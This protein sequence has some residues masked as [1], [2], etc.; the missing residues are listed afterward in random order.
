MIELKTIQ[1]NSNKGG[2]VMMR[3]RKENINSKS[4]YQF[5]GFILIL[6]IAIGGICFSNSQAIFYNAIIMPCIGVLSVILLGKKYYWVPISI[7][8]LSCTVLVIQN[9]I[10]SMEWE[11]SLSGI[12]IMPLILTMIY[13]I[14]VSMGVGIGLLFKYTFSKK[15]G[16]TKSKIGRIMAGILGILLS[17]IIL[18]FTDSLLG[19]PIAAIQ[20]TKGAKV[21]AKEHY[22]HLELEASKATYTFKFHT[23]MVNLSS[24]SSVDTHFYIEYKDGKVIY[25][26]YQSSLEEK[27][28][29][30]QRLEERCTSDVLKLLEQVPGIKNNTTFVTF[31]KE[32]MKDIDAEE[33]DS[34]W[35]D[36]PYDQS[37]TEQMRVIIRCE[38]ED[39]TLEN[40]T[41]IFETS[42]Q[43]LHQ[44]GYKFKS[45]ELFSETKET[46]VMIDDV[47]PE[48]ITSGKLLEELKE[49]SQK[50]EGI[51]GQISVVIREH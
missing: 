27:W 44:E 29:T 9:I 45:Y 20:A 39:T 11:K 33:N 28:N 22:P 43:I 47:A 4:I 13:T 26:S 21:Y 37:L 10:E 30:M 2:S 5:I 14:L 41:R 34:I 24:P 6:I 46:L 42:Y 36:M 32:D 7:A 40:I 38:L 48:S 50:E 51:E 12:L 8:V 3:E 23:Y 19:N 16:V 18:W 15:S 49:A 17:S 25:D 35:I 1:R 31:R